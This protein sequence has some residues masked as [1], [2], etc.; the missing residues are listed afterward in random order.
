MFQLSQ[1]VSLRVQTNH[2][3][4]RLADLLHCILGVLIDFVRSQIG[5]PLKLLIIVR[6]F[7][8]SILVRFIQFGIFIV[9]TKISLLV[10]FQTFFVNYAL[11]MHFRLRFF[12]VVIGVDHVINHLLHRLA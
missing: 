6:L 7:R 8:K 12:L 2:A 3:G 4:R 1:V 11:D 10:C 9:L 5:V